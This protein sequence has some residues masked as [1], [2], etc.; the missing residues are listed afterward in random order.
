MLFVLHGAPDLA[1]TQFLVETVTSC[2]FVLVL[3]RLPADFSARPL[4]RQPLARRSRIG[5]AVGAGRWPA[6]RC[7]AA[8][9]RT[10][11]PISD[12]FPDE[13]VAYGGG[14]QHRQRDPGRHPGLGHHGRDLGAGGGRDR[15]GQPGLPTR[16][17]DLDR[18][19]AVPDA[20]RTASA[21]GAPRVAARRHRR[22][23][24]R[25]SIIFEVVTRL[26]FHTIVLLLR[27]PAVLR[28]QRPRRWVRRRAGRRPGPGGAL[29]GGRPVRAGRGRPGRRR[30]GARRRA[31]AVAVGTA[32]PRCC[33][34]ARSC[35][36]RWSTCTCRCSAL[37]LGHVVFFDVGVYLIVVGLVLDI[38]RS[39]GAEMDRHERGRTEAGAT[40][41]TGAAESDV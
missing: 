34:A 26:I 8:G 3:R 21:T 19:R 32:W 31:A 25:R 28:A 17:R 6:W 15:R 1:L 38:L 11:T 4:R 18:G 20:V 22:C 40:E 12:G 23:A 37:P 13:A 7:V 35:R 36:A 41:R 33:S 39:L 24:R 30:R 29:P 10:A 9:G 14:K 2:V 27:L 16:S 5:V